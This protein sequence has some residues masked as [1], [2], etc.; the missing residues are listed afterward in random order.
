MEPNPNRR[1]Q[2]QSYI[3]PMQD[4][5]IKPKCH[6]QTQTHQEYCIKIQN[7]YENLAGFSPL[8]YNQV[9]K[10]TTYIPQKS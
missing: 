4:F 7:Q 8:A 5:D 9:V 3:S 1:T 2:I 6:T 10:A